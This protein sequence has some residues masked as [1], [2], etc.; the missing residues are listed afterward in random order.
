[1][2]QKRYIE[3]DFHGY[4]VD[5]ALRVVEGVINEIR[6]SNNAETCYFITGHG[7]IRS[8]IYELLSTVYELDPVIPLANSG[9]VTVHV[10]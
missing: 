6:M 3:I 7:R 5:D 1:M 2:R 10:Y 9:M 4:S 8:A